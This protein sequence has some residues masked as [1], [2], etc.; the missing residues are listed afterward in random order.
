MENFNNALI[1]KNDSN[2]LPLKNGD[3]IQIEVCKPD[4][5]NRAGVYHRGVIVFENSAFSIKTKR[6]ESVFDIKPLCNYAPYCKITQ[7]DTID[8]SIDE[9][10]LKCLMVNCLD[11]YNGYTFEKFVDEAKQGYSEYHKRNL[12]N[13]EKYGQP[14]TFS[15]WVNGQ[16]I[17]LT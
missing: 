6:T 16:I 10:D 12:A 1:G 3:T 2:N 8:F 4:A 5:F 13:L 14:K 11:A 7:L 9:D 15:Q 17:S